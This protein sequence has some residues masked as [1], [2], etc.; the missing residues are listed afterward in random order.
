MKETVV[1]RRYWRD[2]LRLTFV[3]LTVWFVVGPV[4]GILL[5]RPLN[6][7]ELFGL[8][9]GF[10]VAQQGAIYVF[11]ALIFIYAVLTDRADRRA[12]QVGEDTSPAAPSH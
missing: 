11:I 2:R 7:L 6:A 12:G 3:L 5:I 10:W 4:L 8:P 9:L 1:S